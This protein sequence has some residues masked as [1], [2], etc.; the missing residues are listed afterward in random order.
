MNQRSGIVWVAYAFDSAGLFDHLDEDDH[1]TWKEYR[2]FGWTSL[3][4]TLVNIAMIWISSMIMFRL[5]EVLPIE[6]TVFWSDLGIARKIYQG[7]ALLVEVPSVPTEE[8]RRPET[9]IEMRDQKQFKCEA[10][11]TSA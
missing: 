10:D 9:M 3:G 6:K 8:T 4:L 1:F 7:K 5:K 2:K 11:G